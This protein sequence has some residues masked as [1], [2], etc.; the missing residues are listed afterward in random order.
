AG[1]LGGVR[2]E[3]GAD[4]EMVGR[5][6]DLVRRDALGGD[7]GAG[8]GEPAAVLGPA[9]AHV[10]GAVD[11]LGDVRQME[12]GGEGAREVDLLGDVEL[13]EAGG[14]GLGLVADQ[15]ADLFDEFEQLGA[16][17]ADQCLAEE[18]AETADVPA[19]LL[20][21]DLAGSV[22]VVH[23]VLQWW[24][25]R[26]NL[27]LARFA[28]GPPGGR[29]RRRGGPRSLLHSCRPHGLRPRCPRSRS[30]PMRTLSEPW[31]GPPRPCAPSRTQRPRPRSRAAVTGLPATLASRGS[32]PRRRLRA[33]DQRCQRN[34]F[35]TVK[36]PAQP[37]M[38]D[39]GAVPA[40]PAATVVHT[41]AQRVRSP[42]EPWNTLVPPPN[43][44]PPHSRLR[45]AKGS[46]PTMS[47]WVLPDGVL[48]EAPSHTPLPHEL[49]D[50]E[51]LLYG[52]YAPLCGFMSE[53]EA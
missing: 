1:G 24:S 23:A 39:G 18:V 37:A 42:S 11:L 12:V 8:L 14:D 35:T 9:A 44:P 36:S 7:L 47:D 25:G 29:S 45:T 4:F 10:A 21:V 27:W 41:P 5:G 22:V 38:R 52:A 43:R 28:M 50:L 30:A 46:R 32:A 33:V 6:G 3:D 40:G 15:A 53:A 13:G 17:L 26:T 34:L 20:L 48:A 19:E 31:T 51:L 49:A 16:L 2:G